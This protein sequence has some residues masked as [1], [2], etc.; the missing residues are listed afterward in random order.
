MKTAKVAIVM[1]SD[2]DLE[3]A[4]KAAEVLE[5][6]KIPFEVRVMSAHRSPEKVWEF[7]SRARE[8]GFEVIIAVAGGAA[9]LAGVIA[10]ATTLPVIG[11]PVA[12]DLAGGLDSLLSTVQMPSGVPVLAVATGSGGAPNAA[13]AAVRILSLSDTRLAAELDEYRAGLA[14]TVDGKDA[15][16]KAQ[17]GK[18]GS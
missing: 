7:A 13:L 15:K 8:N 14:R 6:F 18:G 1:G 17:F 12:T 2:S 3:V 10:G 4:G 16:V 11:I 5:R 9:H